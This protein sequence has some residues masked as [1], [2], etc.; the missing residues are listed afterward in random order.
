MTRIDAGVE[1]ALA[2]DADGEFTRHELEG[3]PDPVRRFFRGAI[4]PA[5]PLA[6]SARIGMKGQIKIGR[7]LPFRAREVLTPHV[8]FLWAARAAGIISGAD[9]FVDGRGGMNWKL[10]GLIPVMRAEGPD[11]SRS[12]AERAAAEAVW[13]PTALLPRFGVEWSAAD[14]SH[15][16]ARY[17]IADYPID[18]RYTLAAD[19]LVQSVVFE[20]WG[21]PDA[22]GEFG[23][24]L[25][26]G[27]FTAHGAFDGVIVPIEGR[28]GWHYGTDQ[29]G[30]GEFFRYRIT[31]LTL[32][33]RRP[34][35]AR[36]GP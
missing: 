14:D 34:S 22:S 27:D 28:L 1:A 29:W 26:G 20:R 19:G 9:R 32:R 3:L 15:V 33:G 8:G 23:L 11:V 10:G 5:T 35:R 2:R 36:S 31:D 24:H 12:A 18:V 6:R 25:F 4:A 30:R 21:D 17:Q 13:V 16:R 7:W